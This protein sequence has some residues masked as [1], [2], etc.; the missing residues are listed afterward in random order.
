MAPLRSLGNIRS[1]F[2]DFYARTGK[3][4]VSPAPPPELEVSGGTKITSGSDTYHVFL[5][6]GSP[7]SFTVANAPGSLTAKLLVVG[8]G[9]S[10]G[11]TADGVS[12]GGGAGGVQYY[13]SYP[14]TNGTTTVVVGNRGANPGTNSDYTTDPS[15]NDGEDTTFG[16]AI[17]YGGG[18]GAHQAPGVRNE[19][20]HNGGSAG[21]GSSYPFPGQPGGTATQPGAPLVSGAGG[22]NYGNAGG[23]G[24]NSNPGVGGGG[25]G[26]ELSGRPGDTPPAGKGGDGQAFPEYP[27]PVLAPAI[28]STN[29]TTI[30]PTGLFAGG[31][32]GGPGSPGTRPGG[33]GGGGSSGPGN[34][35]S[36]G[37]DAT[38]YGSGG[39]G[40]QFGASNTNASPA[41]TAGIVIVKYSS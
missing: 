5:Y 32:A 7:Q 18:G 25:G 12:G 9:G 1:L 10:G 6:T 4:A 13:T 24:M 37:T 17:G 11:F 8:G 38:G 19:T 23:S 27:G 31:G 40:T 34:S 26:S 14:I 33:A 28:P 22:T 29:V 15:I 36:D 16:S 21:G 3:D 41:G 35:A 2:D 20:G 39:S 30:G